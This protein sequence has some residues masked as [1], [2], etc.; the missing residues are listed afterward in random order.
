[1]WELDDKK[2]EH[3]RID[4]FELC[5]WRRFLRVLWT[6][7]RSNQSNSKGKPS[8]IFTGKT[9]GEA[10][11]PILWPPDAKSQLW[12]SFPNAGEDWRWE[13]KMRWLAGPSDSKDMSLSR[14]QEMVKDREAWHAAVHGSQRVGHNW[15]TEQPPPWKGRGEKS[16][17]REDFISY[18]MNI[19]LFSFFF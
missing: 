13:E 14:L 9:D 3:L 12:K 8:W 4:T 15:V 10:E 5:C 17:L 19:F 2:A 16:V 1:M 11:A 7:R 18:N 6:A